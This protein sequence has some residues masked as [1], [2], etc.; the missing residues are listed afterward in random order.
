MRTHA[1][2]VRAYGA[3][4]LRRALVDKGWEISPGAAQRWADRDS[5]PARYWSA[6][7]ELGI[8][9]LMDLAGSNVLTTSAS[10]GVAE[11]PRAFSSKE[12]SPSESERREARLAAFRASLELSKGWRSDAPY[13]PRGDHYE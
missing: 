2:I 3:T 5:I 12:D 6:L 10:A 11:S 4:A 1:Q 13:G 7:A 8:A 9:S